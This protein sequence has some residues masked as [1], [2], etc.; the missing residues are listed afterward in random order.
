MNNTPGSELNQIKEIPTPAKKSR[1]LLWMILGVTLLLTGSLN[2]L[3]CRRI[4][5]LV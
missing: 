3:T 5:G 1:R 2:R 4:G